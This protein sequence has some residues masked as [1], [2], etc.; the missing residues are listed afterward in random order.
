MY[1]N[2]VINDR[3]L[4]VHAELTTGIEALSE[5]PVFLWEMFHLITITL[6][7][8]VW[9]ISSCHN[10]FTYMWLV[11]C[12]LPLVSHE[13]PLVTSSELGGG[14][15]WT[16]W[17]GVKAVETWRD[18]NAQLYFYTGAWSLNNLVRRK[19]GPTDETLGSAQS[20]WGCDIQTFASLND[21]QTNF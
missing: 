4:F 21:G 15:R 3:D 10:M 1:V 18:F 9:F 11:F 7:F 5:W 8:W 17:G 2:K 12:P 6:T 14:S 20:I 16:I 19:S 13:L